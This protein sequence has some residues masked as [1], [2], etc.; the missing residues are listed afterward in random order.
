M[1]RLP[2][3][4]HSTTYGYKES[5]PDGM[6]IHHCTDVSR[7]TQSTFFRMAMGHAFVG[8]FH[9]HPACRHTV[10]EVTEE[11]VS[12]E[13]SKLPQTVEH[14]LLDCPQYHRACTKHLMVHGRPQTLAWLFAHP[15]CSIG[16]LRFLEETWA[17]I[18]PRTTWEPG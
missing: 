9:T 10:G 6:M 1:G 15:L 13:C 4:I 14:V 11:M 8:T 2:L 7:H 17:C 18:T 5:R 3:P 16:L 12:C